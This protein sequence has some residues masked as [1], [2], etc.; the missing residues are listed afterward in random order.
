MGKKQFK[1]TEEA[2]NILQAIYDLYLQN[3]YIHHEDLVKLFDYLTVHQIKICLR[4]L[5]D[6][7][8]ISYIKMFTVGEPD[9]DIINLK[10]LPIGI[11]HIENKELRK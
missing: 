2:Y 7:K 5:K 11:N 9:I 3:P 8:Y 1:I 10:I 6:L 4:Y